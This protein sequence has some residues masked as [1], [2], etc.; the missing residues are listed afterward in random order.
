VALL[1]DLIER[2]VNRLLM[3]GLLSLT[4]PMESICHEDFIFVHDY[5]M[6]GRDDWIAGLRK[7]WSEAPVDF[8]RDRNVLLD[9]R[10]I[11]SMQFTRDI[12][13]VPH[14]ITNV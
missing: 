14:R 12:D 4:A 7:L 6:W 13:G 2:A 9:Q 1:T 5:E 3:L 8:S 11:F 10:D